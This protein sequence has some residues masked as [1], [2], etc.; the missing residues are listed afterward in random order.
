MGE[1]T[2]GWFE[3]RARKREGKNLELQ[4]KNVDHQQ[5]IEGKK[6]NFAKKLSDADAAGV[7]DSADPEELDMRIQ[8]HL[9]RLSVGDAAA[10]E[11]AAALEDSFLSQ[12]DAEEGLYRREWSSLRTHAIGAQARLSGYFP[13]A[14]GYDSPASSGKAASVGPILLTVAV[15]I[16]EWLQ[17]A[18]WFSNNLSLTQSSIGGAWRTVITITI[19]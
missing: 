18:N 7:L 17:T 4:G 13:R 3:G 5:Q 11:D 10:G 8:S 2:D 14:A 19:S 16:V 15:G 6:R 9:D 1:I 12:L